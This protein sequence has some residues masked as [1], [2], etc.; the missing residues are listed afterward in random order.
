MRDAVI[1][2]RPG[3][4]SSPQDPYGGLCGCFPVLSAE[5]AKETDSESFRNRPAWSVLPV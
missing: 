2:M 5:A 3:D 1:E 4:G